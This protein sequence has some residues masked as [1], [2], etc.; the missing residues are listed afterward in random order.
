MFLENVIRRHKEIYVY[1]TETLYVIKN[2]LIL[3]TALR[4]ELYRHI[5]IN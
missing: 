4:D 2:F 5:D 1:W 3:Y